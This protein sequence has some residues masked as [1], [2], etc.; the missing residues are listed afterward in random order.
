M[1]E[2]AR[3]LLCCEAGGGRGHETTLATVA[4]ALSPETPRQAILPRLTH[5]GILEPL[6]D[7]VDRGPH[8]SRLAQPPRVSGLSWANWLL[9]RGFADPETLKMRF[10]WWCE[11][12]RAI[13]PGLVVADFAPTALM[14]AR[15]LGVPTIETGAAFGLP[16]SSLPHFPD[17]LTP[18]QA[19]AHGTKL[20]DAPRPDEAEICDVINQT[21][22]PFG[23]P[24]LE[25]LP[26]IYAADLAL[27]RGIDL[28]DPYAQWRA[29]PL[30]MPIESLPPLKHGEGTE[31]FV[32]LQPDALAAPDICEALRR[33]P[34]AA[35]LVTSGPSE[36]SL[37]I[38]AT[39][40]SLVIEPAPLSYDQIVARSRLILCA[41][42]AGTLG[43]AVLAG[44]PVLA[45][46][47]EHEQMSNAVRAAGQLES[48]RSIPK[49]QRS[50][51]SIMDTISEMCTQSELAEVAQAHAKNLR[52]Q[53]E[54]SALESY[55]RL[56]SPFLG[57]TQYGFLNSSQ[58]TYD[59][60]W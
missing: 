56:L 30:L 22:G 43:L 15:A 4:R 2:P 41:G 36:D 46:P 45:L 54:E 44:I 52:R 1:P 17:L 7:R 32:Y 5:A 29:R 40:P 26:Q 27:P 48:C 39:N 6:C 33:L 59:F 51:D 23:L 13:K 38:I 25:A 8:L 24:Q 42:Q 3:V 37:Q 53:Y 57:G 10:N 11:S 47:I 35:R 16:P 60:R 58:Q 21:L 18:E 14:A 9:M 55:R 31:I 50:A 28:W 34:F 20:K 19:T 12:L 49:T